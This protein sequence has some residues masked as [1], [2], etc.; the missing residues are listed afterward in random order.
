MGLTQ[1]GSDV[2]GEEKEPQFYQITRRL[3][4][5]GCWY[6]LGSGGFEN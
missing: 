2:R 1:E 4:W 6:L 3:L 5:S